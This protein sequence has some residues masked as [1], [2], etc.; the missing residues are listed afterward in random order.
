[1][2]LKS[3]V[4]GVLSS[5]VKPHRIRAGHLRGAHIVTSWHD[6]PAGITGCTERGL[7]AWLQQNVKRGETWLDVGAHYGYTAIALSQFVGRAGRVFAFEPVVA[8]AGC[9]AQT[10]KLNGLTQLTVVPFG[11]G[12]PE[13]L[14]C[15]RLPLERGMADLTLSDG[16]DCWES[17]QIA[18]L[19][20]LWPLLNGGVDVIDGIKIDVQGMEIDVLLGM[21]SILSRHHPKLVIELHTGVDRSTLIELLGHAGYQTR[22]RAIEPQGDALQDELKDDHSYSFSA[23]NP[24][25]SLLSR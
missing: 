10:S 17:L 18:R 15:L 11:L 12:M 21:E 6:Y 16:A 22:A 19:D 20:W 1:V 13:T 7:L 5:R 4:R 23:N 14:A 24:Q 9:V 25:E 2:S 8:T 3:V